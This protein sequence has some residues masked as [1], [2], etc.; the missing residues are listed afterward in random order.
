M[1]S[2]L[3]MEQR[4]D[5]RYLCPEIDNSHKPK[6]RNA[7][8]SHRIFIFHMVQYALIVVPK[9]DGDAVFSSLAGLNCS[10]R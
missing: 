4:H 6:E 7:L 2:W 9:F 3:A 5:K 10:I 1:R 8:E